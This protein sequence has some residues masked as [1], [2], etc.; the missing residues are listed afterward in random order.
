MEQ[1]NDSEH[2]LPELTIQSSESNEET[3]ANQPSI[4]DQINNVK[5]DDL[6]P[7]LKE[8]SQSAIKDVIK[9]H[10]PDNWIMDPINA[11][12]DKKTDSYG[13]PIVNATH[14]LPDWAQRDVDALIGEI[15]DLITHIEKLRI[16]ISDAQSGY[17]Q[18]YS[19]NLYDRPEDELKQD[20]HESEYKLGNFIGQAIVRKIDLTGTLSLRDNSLINQNIAGSI[21]DYLHYYENEKYYNSKDGYYKEG[22]PPFGSYNYQ[23]T[24]YGSDVTE[25]I[26][27]TGNNLS[28]IIS[29]DQET[30]EA[31]NIS[32]AVPSGNY[33][34]TTQSTG[35]S[36]LSGANVI[37]NGSNGTYDDEYADVPIGFSFKFYECDDSDNNTDVRVSTNGYLSFYQQGGGAT[38]GTDYSNDVIT[39]TDDPDGFVAPIWDDLEVTDNGSTDEISYLTE[40]STG[41]RTFTVEWYSMSHYN[42]D[43]GYLYAQ[44]VL[45]E[46]NGMVELKYGTD[47]GTE[48][49]FTS[50]IED[51]SGTDGD[52]GESGDDNYESGH[53][54][55]FQPQRPPS[56]VSVSG[57]GTIC[58]GGSR[59]LSVSHSGGFCGGC[60]WQYQWR[61]TGGT[62][63]QD[64][65]TSSGFTASPSSTTSYRCRVRC[66]C[67]SCN[68]TQSSNSTTVTVNSDPSV[69]I[70]ADR[71]DVCVGGS[72]TLEV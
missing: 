1:E 8:K 68:Y 39:N 55:K 44:A 46:A 54:Y 66:A 27:N 6:V 5:T 49:S 65:S 52:E 2:A 42:Y 40:G 25:F 32:K 4:N 72:V 33:H 12:S 63:V 17:R 37:W 70:S 9:Q 41:S 26:R 29:L 45:Y 47:N 7:E 38:D 69:S 35:M 20:L 50:G 13:N 56:S 11:D 60:S 31:S 53:N 19:N 43:G 23:P 71:T 34:R 30:I 61:T 36:N 10:L 3:K 15:N 59:N 24:V 58:T 14:G 64:W 67:N 18:R 51:Y 28:E 21:V 16:V 22:T 48:Y 62:V 57:G